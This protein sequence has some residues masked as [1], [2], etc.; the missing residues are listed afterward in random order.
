M[1]LRSL[2]SFL[3]LTAALLLAIAGGGLYWILS[4]SPLPL[5]QGGVNR[6]PAASVFV[7]KQ[8]PI[9]VSLLVK[10]EQLE[11]F[12]QFSATPS[13]RR[14][15][16]R[17]LK[18]VE[19]S[20]LANTGLNYE[21]EIRPWL[22]NEITL[23]VTSLDYDRNRTNGTK[24]GY[25][26]AVQA[27]DKELAKE[28]LQLS[29]SEQAIAGTS[30]LVL[31][32]YKGVKL[33]FKR[34][35]RAVVNTNFLASAVVADFVLFANDITVLRE[36]INNIQVTDLNLKF[37]PSYQDALKTIPAPRIGLAYANLPALSAWIANNSV[38]ETP[39]AKQSLTISLSL[40]SR[41]LVAK[42]GLIGV[43]GPMQE[44][45]ALAKPVGTLAYI[46]SDSIL[47]AAGRDLQQFWAQV[48]TGLDADSPLQQL[49]KRG[50]SSLEEP[51]GI[52][53]ADAVFRWV[54]G[55]YSIAAVPTLDK[56]DPDWIF[57]AE[58][59]PG[60]DSEAAIAHLDDIAKAQGYNVETL[61]L[62]N[63]SVTAWTKLTTTPAANQRLAQLETQVRGVHL[64]LDNYTLFATSVEAMSRGIAAA[65]E[66]LINSEKFQ[67]AIAAL[68]QKNDG[69]FYLD[70]NQAEPLI[71][72]KVPAIRVVEFAIKPILDNLRSLTLSSQGS[73]AG[74]E[75]STAYFNLGAR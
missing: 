46:P 28:Y 59:L 63:R 36:A 24:P 50:V 55:D 33:L 66:P 9:M 21:A 34:P 73:I 52:D 56:I 31:E 6:E 54:Q 53:L 71:E 18:K 61:P 38:A 23:A 10:P 48:E 20:L 67:Q 25:L 40:E 30:D 12:A 62:L 58:K 70:W 72:R 22:G 51:L 3:A 27:K 74:I 44:R 17:E 29:Y 7:S 26:L 35:R 39:E 49:L 16:R 57:V 1:K 4:Q 64:D 75:R 5:L 60:T 2:L 43:S 42:T 69:Y 37:A 65:G 11:G 15:S 45:P 8:A 47:S 41:G 14:R 68:P 19:K 32:D 13:N